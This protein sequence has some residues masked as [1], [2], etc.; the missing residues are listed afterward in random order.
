MTRKAHPG[1]APDYDAVVIGAGFCGL[2]FL[3]YALEKGLR[4]VALDKQAD[5]GGL[6]NWLPAWQD[7]QN[8][9]RDFAINDI[10]LGGKDQPHVQ[11]H[12]RSW[13]EKYSLEPHI[14]LGCEVISASWKNDRWHV[15]TAVG[16]ITGRYLIAATGVQNRPWIPEIERERANV[17]ELHSSELH[18][19][20]E[21]SDRKVTVVGGGAS[22]FDLLDLAI[23]HGARELRWVYRSTR[24]F[25]PSSRQKHENGMNDLRLMARIQATRQ[26]T[27]AVSRMLR[28]LI[29]QKYDHFG[30]DSIRPSR[31]FDLR[32]HQ[33]IPGRPLMLK[34]LATICRHATEVRRIEGS[35]VILANGERFETDTI[36]WGTGYRMD[37]SYLDLEEYREIDRLAGLSPKLGSLVRSLHNPNLFFVGMSLIESTGTTPFFA[38]VESKSIASHI[39]GECQIPQENVP[40]HVPHWDLLRL[41]AR[42]DRHNYPRIWWRARS[43]LS[44]WWYA[45]HPSKSVKV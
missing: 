6:W 19:P 20:D 27:P 18:R 1:N 24:W 31:R 39:A 4:C 26:S 10:P 34:N 25:L 21:L 7:I 5:V 36:L 15:K 35:E 42:F 43:L 13:V 23:Q 22:A 14:R 12:A 41:F 40:H 16:E 3:A 29:E 30:L 33:A 45:R 37:L 38:A 8:R 9:P 28:N 32:E 44:A 17:I 11:E 2:I